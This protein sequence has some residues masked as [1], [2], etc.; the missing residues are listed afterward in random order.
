MDFFNNANQKSNSNKNHFNAN[1]NNGFNANVNR[2]ND[3]TENQNVNKREI[4]DDEVT[5]VL[6]LLLI[7][8]NRTQLK[9]AIS[10]TKTVMGTKEIKHFQPIIKD[11]I[12]NLKAEFDYNN[13][14]LNQQ[15]GL[16]QTT[17]NRLTMYD[18]KEE[19][20]NVLTLNKIINKIDE[21]IN[22]HADVLSHFDDD[23]LL[24]ASKVERLK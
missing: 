16:S 8:H 18:F 11:L 19:R 13:K 12:K 17:K 2:N 3:Y 15:L 1:Q 22:T 4:K 21:I 7:K 23:F 14:E 24:T 5:S 9:N 10:E 20:I 6:R